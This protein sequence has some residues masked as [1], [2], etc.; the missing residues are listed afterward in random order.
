MTKTDLS[1]LIPARNEMF[2]AKTVENILQ[3]IRGNTEV[4]I[5]LDGQWADPPIPD[6][7]RVIIIYHSESIGQRAATNEACRLS[8]AKYVMK[9]D[10]HCAFD[11]GFDV[12]MMTEMHDDWTMVPTMYN[13]HAFDWV[14]K[15]CKHRIYQ[16]PTPEKCPKC[17]GEMYRDILWEPRKSRKSNHYRFD[18]T[19]HFQYWGSYGKRKEAQGDIA[20]TMSLQGSCFMMTRDKYWEL[21]ICDEEH[22]SWGQQGTE[23]ACKTWLSGGRVVVN[24]KTWYSH[25][26]R[27]QGGDFGFPY[28]IS[29]RQVEH[30]R[31]YSREL[32]LEGRWPKAVHDLNWL[33]DKFKPVPD[34]HEEGDGSSKPSSDPTKGI[35][36][37]TDNQVPMKIGNEARKSILKAKLP[38]VSTSLKPMNFGKNIWM[39]GM[40][41][42]YEAYFKQILTALENSESEIIFFCEHDWLYHPSHFDFTPQSKD[43]F[44]YN[45]N[46][47]RLRAEDGLA[48][49]YDTQMVPGLVAYRD[50][51]IG[52]YKQVVEYLEKIGFSG[53]N[54]RQ[55]GFEPGTH[56][57]VSFVGN[58]KIERFDS[59]FPNIDIRHTG[60]LT[61]S[62]WNQ[63]DFRNQA[64]CQN[65]QETYN[66]PGW[67]ET[68]ELIKKFKRGE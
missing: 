33:L 13:L 14:C 11:E 20:D 52:Y 42:G 24:K 27:T 17:G 18:K 61:T 43:T 16:G 38:I 45:W 3:N 54:A 31:K 40:E 53:E 6:D 29:G 25:M 50:L 63:D 32:F 4:I 56:K 23:V 59:E 68:T 60:N 21:D 9:V 48:V 49:K 5:N 12:K 28:P 7:K 64:N 65:W 58:Y 35:I 46:W 47:W 1:I 8:K 26:F 57:R 67:G 19:L 34:W 51:L 10:A 37:Y 30:A 44:Y 15:H 62:K 66:I 36:Y 41:R 39:K 2:L 22:G 55:V